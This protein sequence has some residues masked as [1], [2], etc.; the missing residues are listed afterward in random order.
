MP[1]RKTAEPVERSER[2]D[3]LKRGLQ[4]G[5]IEDYQG[6][7][8]TTTGK[9]FYIENAIIWNLQNDDGVRIGQAATFG[10]WKFLDGIPTK[11][12]TR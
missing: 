12:G 9:R 10:E 6:I 2:A 11:N 1:S 8:I 5:F 4:K 7:R 3:M